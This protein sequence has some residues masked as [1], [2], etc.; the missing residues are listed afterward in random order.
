MGQRYVKRAQECA[1]SLGHACAAKI[2]RVHALPALLEEVHPK[3][4]IL[5]RG[6]SD[7]LRKL[8]EKAAAANIR[9]MIRLA[10]QNSL[11]FNDDILKSIL[12]D[13]DLKSDLAHPNA[14]GYALTAE[15]LAKLLKK[16]GAV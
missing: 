8:D 5:Y 16:V 13:N 1:I 10:K 15:A 6:G 3:L 9:Q 14:K 12:R 7:F 11:P 2:H 4:L